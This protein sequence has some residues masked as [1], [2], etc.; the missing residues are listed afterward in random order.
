MRVF[1]P[2]EKFGIQSEIDTVFRCVFS[3]K[4][5]ER[6]HNAGSHLTG[7]V[8]PQLSSQF[9]ANACKGSMS[10]ATRRLPAVSITSKANFLKREWQVYL[11]K[12]RKRTF[13]FSR[14]RLLS[15]DK[16]IEK[17]IDS[18]MVS[19]FSTDVKV[20]G[21]FLWSDARGMC[22][23]ECVLIEFWIDRG[24]CILRVHMLGVDDSNFGMILFL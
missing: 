3:W 12:K 11:K 22:I 17:W 7:I 23:A 5:E 6:W 1:R 24:E 8:K 10:H 13:G 18:L 14:H 4:T 15:S 19:R 9:T 16:V 20:F 21:S 2:P